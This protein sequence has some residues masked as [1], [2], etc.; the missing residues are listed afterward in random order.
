METMN[1]DLEQGM[2]TEHPLLAPPAAGAALKNEVGK[3]RRKG[4]MSTTTR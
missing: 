3:G 1:P 4:G 2:Q